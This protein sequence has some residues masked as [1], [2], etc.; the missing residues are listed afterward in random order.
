MKLANALLL[1]LL[2]SLHVSAT[3]MRID[4][5]HIYQHQTTSFSNNS[6]IYITDGKITNIESMANKAKH[7]DKVISGNAGFI[8]PGLIDLHVHLAASGSSYGNEYQNVPVVNN[9][10][11]SLFLGVTGVADLFSSP[12]IKQQVSEVK[13]GSDVYFA[14][15]LFTNKNG[16]GTQ[17]GVETFVIETNDDIENFWPQHL[18]S[19]PQLTKAVIETFGGQGNTLTDTQLRDLGLRSKKAGL[20]FFVH[21]SSLH[22]A[23]RAIRAGATVLAHG[24]NMEPIDNEFIDLMKKNK[25]VYVPTL[26]VYHNQGKEFENQ[27]ISKQKTLLTTVHP[28]LQHCLLHNVKAPSSWFVNIWNKRQVASDNIAKLVENNITIGAGSDAGNPYVLHG[29][30]L[31]HEIQAL[32]AAG[33]TKGEAINAATINANKALQQKHIGTLTIGAQA[34]LVL[35]NANPLNNLNALSEISSVFK[36]GELVDRGK[37][38]RENL[39]VEPEGQKCHQTMVSETVMNSIIDDFSSTDN[40]QAFSDNVQGGTSTAKTWLI[41]ASHSHDVDKKRNNKRDSKQRI[42]ASKLGEGAPFGNWAGAQMLFNKTINVS[43]FTGVELTFTANKG[44]IFFSL[45]DAKVQDWDHFQTMLSTTGERQT[46]K[47][48]FIQLKQ[49]GFG[50]AYKWE[51]KVINGLSFLWRS[52]PQQLT[53]KLGEN[54]II[55]HSLKYY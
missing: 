8:I 50:Q 23:K 4:D 51:G 47:V 34:D 13:F 14:G 29:V 5:V 43:V 48:P 12:D 39:A 6:R 38:K 16:H 20:P 21:I 44:V 49:F 54:K 46:I 11:T 45:Y 53:K 26:S 40:W 2:F 7:A 3:D 17:F 15:Q 1:T 52:M 41:D 25:V 28:K 27:F 22:D 9:L 55:L 30:S 42:I 32:H 35:L 37:L 36:Q 33:L 19:K 18:A 10:N 31:H 24:V